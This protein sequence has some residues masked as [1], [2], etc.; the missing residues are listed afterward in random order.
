LGR[1]ATFLA[2]DSCL[3]PYF[4]QRNLLVNEFLLESP[5]VFSHVKFL[6]QH[7]PSQS[8]LRI[9]LAALPCG[10]HQRPLLYSIIHTSTMSSSPAETRRYINNLNIGP[11]EGSAPGSTLVPEAKSYVDFSVVQTFVRRLP[12]LAA[13]VDD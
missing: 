7:V 8:F 2:F 9:K 3:D 13:Y 6:V 4:S 12:L 5:N 1:N 11:V 10:S